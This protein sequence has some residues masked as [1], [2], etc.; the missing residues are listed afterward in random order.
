MYY[1]KVMDAMENVQD[2]YGYSG[3]RMMVSYDG[4]PYF[5]NENSYDGGR[6]PNRGRYSMDSKDEMRK[7]LEMAL[8]MAKTEPERQNI[9][10]MLDNM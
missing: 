6:Y 1:I 4:R 8:S 10:N 5:D 3:R 9:R 2:E 7:H